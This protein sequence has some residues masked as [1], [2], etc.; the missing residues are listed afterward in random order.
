MKMT[1]DFR[2]PF[3]SNIFKRGWINLNI[4]SLEPVDKKN[5]YALQKSTQLAINITSKYRES[6][7]RESE[8]KEK[9]YR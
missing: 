1:T 8:R 5:R 4:Q 9:E 6:A 2:I 7:T 3:T